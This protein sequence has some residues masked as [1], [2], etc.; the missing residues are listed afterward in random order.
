MYVTQ[1]LGWGWLNQVEYLLAAPHV[2]YVECDGVV[3]MM[4]KHKDL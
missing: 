1:V 3:H 2:K 4:Q